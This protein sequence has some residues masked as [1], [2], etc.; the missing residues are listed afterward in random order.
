M[1]N[2]VVV[3]GTV[4]ARAT[5]AATQWGDAGPA[6]RFVLDWYPGGGQREYHSTIEM[7]GERIG[8]GWGATPCDAELASRFDL[9]ERMARAQ[10]VQEVA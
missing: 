3:L 7:G 6:V 1:S 8:E 9:V 10:G 4:L 5:R 2:A